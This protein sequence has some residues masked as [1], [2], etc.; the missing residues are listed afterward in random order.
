MV[1]EENRVKCRSWDVR[2]IPI[3]PL[4]RPTTSCHMDVAMKIAQI[5]YSWYTT[6]NGAHCE[7]REGRSRLQHRTQV[8]PKINSA[9]QELLLED[10]HVP[11]PL[12]PYVLD[13]GISVAIGHRVSDSTLLDRKL[14]QYVSSENYQTTEIKCAQS[15]AGKR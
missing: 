8:F 6:S 14:T 15:C 11:H 12:D 13:F 2:H 5:G 3:P 9:I 10:I 4:T 1:D 7:L